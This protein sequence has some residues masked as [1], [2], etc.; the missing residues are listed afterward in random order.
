[1][2]KT[3][4]GSL[5]VHSLCTFYVTEYLQV[6]LTRSFI[7]KALILLDT[8][9]RGPSANRTLGDSTLLDST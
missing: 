3:D 5:S 4:L 1:M 2:S 7:V 9:S 6:P 8:R